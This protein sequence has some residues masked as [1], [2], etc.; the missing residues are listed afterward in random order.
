M[1]TSPTVVLVH[2]A[3]ADAGS[4]AGVAGILQSAGVTVL[5]PA[6]P[7]RSVTTDSAYIASV[8]SQ[9]DGPVLA[10]G[11]SYGGAVITNAATAA[12]NVVGLVFI[13]AFA[14]DQGEKLSDVT[15]TSADSILGTALLQRQFPTGSGDDTAVELYVD[16]AKFHEVFA[17]DL[18][19][20][21]SAVFAASQRPVAASAF[22]DVTGVPAWKNLPSWAVVGTGDK[23]AGADITREHAQRA[24]SQ[25][26]ELTG[27][28]LAF[29]AQPQA[30]AD[31]ILTAL[32]AVTK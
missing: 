26:T 10:V 27:S 2:G 15:A 31:V 4:W 5:A 14:P 21:Q 13:S 19:A 7:L 8:I 24:G 20:A 11:H 29:V 18:P 9:I 32:K 28:H 30:V 23:A 1:S 12:T 3:F 16:P 25:L 6:N 17:A 22:D